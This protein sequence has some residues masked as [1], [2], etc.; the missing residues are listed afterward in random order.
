[1]RA[2]E[3]LL[4]GLILIVL[5]FGGFV[6]GCCYHRDVIDKPQDRDTLIF[7]SYN[8]DSVKLHVVLKDGKLQSFWYSKRYYKK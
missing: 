2:T 4:F 7:K 5:V 1:M 6:A 8:E 3:D